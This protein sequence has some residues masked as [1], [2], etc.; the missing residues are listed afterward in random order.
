VEDAAE[1]FDCRKLFIVG[2]VLVAGHCVVYGLYR[3]KQFVVWRQVW[4]EQAMV[5][6]F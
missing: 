6:K 4:R 3:M 5:S 1:C 2:F